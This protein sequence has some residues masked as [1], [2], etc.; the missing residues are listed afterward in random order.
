MRVVGIDGARAGAEAGWVAVALED[1]HLSEVGFFER[2]ADVLQEA[3]DAAIVGVDMPLGHDDPQGQRGG[4]RLA[5]EA[6]RA[7]LGPRRDSVFLIPPLDLFALPTHEDARREAAHRGVLA[8]SAQAWALRGRLLDANAAWVADARLHEVHP[9]VSFQTLHHQLGGQ[10][11]LGH[12]KRTWNG[13]FERLQLLQRAGLRP[14]RSFGGIGRA[15][16]DDVLDA[17]IVAW[18]AARLARGEAEPLPASP[19]ADLA[20]RKPVAIWR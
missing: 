14:A 9:E 1:G 4:R 11:S 2:I 12:A 7:F 13:L 20:T 10:G 8:P 19:P 18:T 5:D 15:G 3:R 17:T 16:P 6:A